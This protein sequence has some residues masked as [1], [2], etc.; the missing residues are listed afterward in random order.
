MLK[1]S[2]WQW[3]SRMKKIVDSYLGT[4]SILYCFP[5]VKLTQR[6]RLSNVAPDYHL[7][8]ALTGIF[9]IQHYW[10]KKNW[11][12]RIFK[13]HWNYEPWLNIY[14][15]CLNL[16]L[17]YFAANYNPHPSVWRWLARGCTCILLNQGSRRLAG[18]FVIITALL[19]LA[20]CPLPY[21]ASSIPLCKQFELETRPAPSRAISLLW[22]EAGL[23]SLPDSHCTCRK[24]ERGEVRL[25]RG[26]GLA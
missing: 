25:G 10:K 8:D 12:I 22:W 21:F 26:R 6:K 15:I 19:C 1:A 2:R 9:I 17:I 16:N 20:V 18:V 11:F 23:I 4:V 13:A 3:F 14:W 5:Q 24:I 7:N